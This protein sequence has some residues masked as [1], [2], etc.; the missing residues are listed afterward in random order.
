MNARKIFKIEGMSCQHCEKAIEQ[1][2]KIN[3]VGKAK[4]DHAK[5]LARVEYDPD[6]ILENE[7]IQ[8]ITDA[9]YNVKEVTIG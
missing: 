4:A 5:K 3:G 2:L 1:A 7:I 9:G 8:I 6:V